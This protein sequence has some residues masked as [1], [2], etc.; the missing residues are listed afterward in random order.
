MTP[1]SSTPSALRSLY[2]QCRQKVL[3]P[4]LSPSKKRLIATASHLRA[5]QITTAD[6]NFM[7]NL[8]SL[9]EHSTMQPTAASSGRTTSLTYKPP[10]KPHHLHILSRRHNCHITLTAGNRD[11]L[12]SVSSGILNIRK[13]ARG[14]YDSAFQL[15]TF[16][17]AKIK[18]MGL[19]GETYTGKGGPIRALE[20]CF[21]DFGPG[22]EAIRKILM[23][24]EGSQLR[25]RVTRVMDGT[26]LKFGGTRSKKPRRR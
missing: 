24:Q 10:P 19:L 4:W 17:M 7:A 20:I 5:G 1:L 9:H 15:G 14:N 16:V 22:R 25:K 26:R 3:F 23:G 18:N 21:R 12:L 11:V 13:S 6:S 8:S 2:N